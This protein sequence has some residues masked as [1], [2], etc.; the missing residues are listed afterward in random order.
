M[1]PDSAASTHVHTKRYRGTFSGVTAGS[2]CHGTD[3]GQPRVTITAE[4]D[5]LST[6]MSRIYQILR[7]RFSND[8]PTY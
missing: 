1:L 5:C 2:I 4:K 3:N 8:R 6:R 7:L